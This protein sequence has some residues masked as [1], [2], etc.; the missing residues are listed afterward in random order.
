MSTKR[1]LKALREIETVT[2]YDELSMNLTYTKVSE[3]DKKKRRLN[4]KTRALISHD[5]IITWDNRGSL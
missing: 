1:V 5:R 2:R 4:A 3:L